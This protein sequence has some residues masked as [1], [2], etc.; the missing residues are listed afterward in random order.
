MYEIF[1][2]MSSC[3]FT[4]FNFDKDLTM[5]NEHSVVTQLCKKRV[6][7]T[8]HRFCFSNTAGS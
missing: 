4:S 2:G 5:E 7:L 3:F 6:R 1:L 8:K